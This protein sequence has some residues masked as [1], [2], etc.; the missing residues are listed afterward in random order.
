MILRKE[1]ERLRDIL[2]ERREDLETELKSLPD[3]SLFCL[4]ADG[5]WYYY[6]LLPK[7]GNRK[8]E[9]R[10]GISRD[11]EKIFGLVRKRYITKALGR[12]DKDLKVVEMALRRYVDTDEGSVMAKFMEKH[13]ELSDGI[14]H[15]RQLD[16]A[17]AKDYEKQQDF[18]AEKRKHTAYD[19]TPMLSKNEMY[20][21]ARLEHFGI[22]YRYEDTVAH[23]D[24]DRIPDFKIRRPRDGKIIYWEHLGLTGD[25]GYMKGNELKFTEY[26]NADIVPWDNLIIT[27]DTPDGGIDG[28]IID[29]MIHG[30]LL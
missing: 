3:G 9:K 21:A 5:R 26:E 15:G 12:I 13:P 14:Y 28:K 30:W 25:D 23:P 24:V 22:P 29:A 7:K 18:Y 19:G 1:L 2:R 6:Q 20:I 4:K 27:Y 11:T 16:E 8:K 17:W 10:I